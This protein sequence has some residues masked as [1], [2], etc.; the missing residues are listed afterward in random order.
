MSNTIRRK[1]KVNHTRKKSV[2]CQFIGDELDGL[3]ELSER[4]YF[5][6]ASLAIRESVKYTLDHKRNKKE[7]Q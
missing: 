1:K 5:G 3:E 4:F 7:V 6:N 2:P